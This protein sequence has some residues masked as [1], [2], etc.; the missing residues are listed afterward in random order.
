MTLALGPALAFGPV[1]MGYTG[2]SLEELSQR[3]SS[4]SVIS[5]MRRTYGKLHPIYFFGGNTV[6]LLLGSTLTLFLATLVSLPGS[7]DAFSR[8][9]QPSEVSQNQT[10]TTQLENGQDQ[11]GKPTVSVPEPTTLMLLGSGVGLFMLYRRVA[12]R[13]SG[14]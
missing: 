8:R 13:E 4:G 10:R 7:A 11:D 3:M 2:R 14:K 6:K 9:P 1:R 12:A 5:T